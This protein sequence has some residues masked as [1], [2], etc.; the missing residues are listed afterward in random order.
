MKIDLCACLIGPHVGVMLPFFID[1]LYE[2][3]DMTDVN[4]HLAHKECSPEVVKYLHK[5]K[6]EKGVGIH[7]ITYKKIE[8]SQGRDPSYGINWDADYNTNLMLNEFG[9]SEWF[10]HIHF[11]VELK[12]DWIGFYREKM[13]PKVG[14]IGDGITGLMM[15]RRR[16]YQQCW[17]GFRAWSWERTGGFFLCKDHYGNHR[18]RAGSDPRCNDKSI[19]IF[20]WDHAELL[21]LNMIERGWGVVTH[22]DIF[23][24]QY[25]YHLGTGTDHCGDTE[26]KRQEALDVLTRRGLEPI[27]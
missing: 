11:D 26:L 22:P 6:D 24:N 1:S 7:E 17:V 15:I 27:L 8:F 23:L 9:D 10:A 2:K 4:L 25:R 19:Q 13:T 16:A 21:E 5:I 18:I 14:M 12:Q 3:T 20:A